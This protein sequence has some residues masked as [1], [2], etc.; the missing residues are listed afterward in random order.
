[1]SKVFILIYDLGILSLALWLYRS[2]NPWFVF[3][4]AGIFLIPFLRRIGICK[5]LD[6]REKY[7]DRFSSNI[8]LVTVFLLTMLII[9][10]G[11]KLEHDLY[12]AFIVVPLVAKA[13]FYAG[14]TYSKKT[15]ITYVG[16]VMSLIYLGFVLLSHGI[17]LTS[18]IEAIP[19]IVFLVITEL[20]RK[21]RLAGIGY[22][23]F[24]VLISYVYIPNLTNSSLLITYVI[25]LLPM[26]ILTIR[27]FQKEE[28]GSE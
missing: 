13:S 15:V 2:I 16:R 11:S 14:F 9:A 28:T 4:A 22:L 24:A 19:G 1:M 18:L 26:I 21:W 5:E 20:A 8:A 25:L 3:T 27:A 7:Y 6:E 12:F 23:A 17:S 10:L